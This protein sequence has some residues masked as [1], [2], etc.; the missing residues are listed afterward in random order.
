MGVVGMDLVEVRDRVEAPG[1]VP[2]RLAGGNAERPQHDGQRR[3]DLLAEADPVAEEELVDGVR[4]GGQ[5]RDVLRVA[6]VGADPVDERLHLVV[7][8]GVAGGDRPGQ[9]QHARVRVRQL[10][11]FA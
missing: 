3:R 1:H 11:F 6:R 5:R 2:D 7:R 9:R 10:L 4:T 8:V